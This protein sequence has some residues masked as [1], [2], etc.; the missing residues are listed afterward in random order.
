MQTVTS[1]S[2]TG[3]ADVA[4]LADLQSTLLD[5]ASHIEELATSN[6]VLDRLHAITSKSLPLYVLAAARFPIRDTD[7]SSM[8]PGKSVFLHDEIPKG[9]WEEYDALARGK[10]RSNLFVARSSLASY[11]WTEVRRLF[12]PIGADRWA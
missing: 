11:T 1:S 8:R 4:P 2:L 5:Y 10:F 9:W 6:D 12:D 7:W 3:A